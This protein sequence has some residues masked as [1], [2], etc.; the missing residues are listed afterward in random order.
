MKKTL[1]STL[2]TI[3]V[4]GSSTGNTLISAY[5]ENSENVTANFSEIE[6]TFDDINLN[7]QN[8]P[9][10]LSNFGEYSYNFRNQLDANNGAVYDALSVLTTPIT[11]KIVV[12]LPEP[13][14]MSLNGLPSTSDYTEEDAETF[15]NA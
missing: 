13:V 4:I 11:D 10:I 5:A 12:T 7:F 15:S 3:A 6:Y 1:I 8:T 2:C 14:T 9:A